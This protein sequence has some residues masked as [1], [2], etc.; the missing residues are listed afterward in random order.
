MRLLALWVHVLGAA[1]WLGGLVY[2]VHVVGPRTSQAP[3]FVATA[4]RARPFAWTALGVTTLTGFYNVTRLGPLERVM[5]S[6][7]ALL[8]AGKF[9]LVLIV[10][11]LAAQ[12]DFAQIPRL[13]RM[14]AAGEDPRPALAAIGWLDR[15]AMLLGV[16]VIYLGL[17]V[18]RS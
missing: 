4:R 15:I 17:A 9:L 12:R 1:V 13:A 11:S 6:G 8:L 14:L 3:V 5:E 18:S 2:Q 7:A 10:I 16:A